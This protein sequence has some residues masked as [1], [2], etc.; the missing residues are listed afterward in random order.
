MCAWRQ[1]GH[2]RASI[3]APRAWGVCD[4]CGFR[5][6]RDDLSW[7]FDWRSNRLMNLRI[8]VCP[9]CLDTPQDQYRPIVVPPDPVPIMNPRP[10][11]YAPLMP[12][13]ITDT[14]GNQITDTTG[15]YSPI[16]ATSAPYPP[17]P[18]IAGA[19]N[20][21]TPQAQDQY[22]IEAPDGGPILLIPE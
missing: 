7:Q 10:E 19:Y 3:T 22:E 9:H 20:Y 11:L 5:W 21:T 4:R 14:Y 8:L 16:T 15:P 2:A 17:A 6:N 18:G 12:Y 13:I 1:H